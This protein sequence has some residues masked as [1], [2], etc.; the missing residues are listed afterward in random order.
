MV[1]TATDALPKNVVGSILQAIWERSQPAK[2]TGPWSFLPARNNV[3]QLPFTT[4]DSLD[5]LREQFSQEQLQAARVLVPQSNGELE[6]NPVLRS[7][8][9]IGLFLPAANAET[10]RDIVN[11]NGSLTTDDPPLLH[12][13]LDQTAQRSG[14]E[15]AAG[16]TCRMTPHSDHKEKLV[17]VAGS[18][19]DLQVLQLLGLP[20]TTAAGLAAMTGQH[21]RR[22]FPAN[23]N[24]SGQALRSAEFIPLVREFYR[25]VLVGWQVAELAHECP[26]EIMAVV[27]KLIKAEHAYDFEISEHAAVWVPDDEE[28]DDICTAT[29]FEDP[30]LGRKR[31]C[32]SVN[33]AMFPLADFAHVESTHTATDYAAARR[34]LQGAVTD[35]R[36]SKFHT[37]ATFERL[38][39]LHRLF[40]EHVVRRMVD[41]AMSASNSVERGL[42]L[43]AAE[44]ME[45]WHRS[46]YLVQ[47]TAETSRFTSTPFIEAVDPEGWKKRLPMVNVMIKIHSE[48]LRGK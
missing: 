48:L 11:Q 6:L 35:A 33:D 23:I 29:E 12:C 10:F 18:D 34:Q 14:R 13:V 42:R 38:E 22:L 3:R 36:Q 37:P 28:F 43:M 41:D 24:H 32:K 15:N 20:S 17:F 46:S 9:N 45:E 1:Q 19:K 21:L 39:V 44:Q 7:E 27:H 26:G 47:S 25:W 16:F 4:T 5:E 31:I 30:E 8:S 2:P 40:D